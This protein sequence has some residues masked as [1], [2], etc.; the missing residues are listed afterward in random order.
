[1]A[2]GDLDADVVL[3]A[4]DTTSLMAK[5]STMLES[6]RA[7]ARE[8]QENLRIRRS[9]DSSA[10]S[11]M[12]AD[13][14]QAI[15]YANPAMDA[16]LRAAQPELRSVA[17]SFDATQLQGA[18]LDRLHPEL[19]SQ[20]STIDTLAAPRR[21]S[22]AAGRRQFV[23]TLSPIFDP[24]GKRL[25]TSLEW[26]DRTQEAAVEAELAQIIEAAARGDFSARVSLTGKE[27]FFLQLAQGVNQMLENGES[28][29]AEVNKVLDALSRG[30]LTGSV[31]RDFDGVF[32]ALKD[33]REPHGGQPEAD[34]RQGAHDLADAD[35]CGGAGEL[36]GAVAQPGANEQAA[37]VEETSSS[38]E[39]MTAS[40]E[41]NADNAKVTDS[42]A[43]QAA[44]EAA[45][46]GKAGERD[47]VGDEAD[48]GQ[49]RDRRRHRVP[50]EPAG[51]ETRR[52]RRR[53]RAS[54]AA[55]SRWWPRR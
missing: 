2:R 7:A 11:V 22:L 51:V 31:G 19:A 34:D 6:L 3:R 48:R 27:G 54:T 10:S 53:A 24:S 50:D 18:A 4:G 9:L 25:G 37:S 12:I 33:K 43:R 16:L 32:G 15:V 23:L 42:T 30:D 46:G 5:L 49:D 13:D 21:L 40:I 47:G 39:Q 36:D 1:M 20:R 38:V 28:G 52:S 17:P 45:E 41:H 8:A 14:S 29:L 35:Q 44:G 26:L 55:V